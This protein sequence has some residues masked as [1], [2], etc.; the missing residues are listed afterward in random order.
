MA[1]SRPVSDAISAARIILKDALAA[2]YSDEDLAH[3][4]SEG[5]AAMYRIRPDLMVGGYTE[6]PVYTA[7]SLS[8]PLPPAIADEYMEP[9][10]RFIAGHAELRDD[11]FSQDGRAVTLL[12]MMRAALLT[13]GV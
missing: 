6:R 7:A 1:T 4:A 2:R 12:Q 3:Y 10:A 13:P 5:V 8:T 11:Q 9:L